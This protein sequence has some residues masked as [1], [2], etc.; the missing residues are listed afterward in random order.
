MVLTPLPLIITANVAVGRPWAHQ[1]IAILGGITA[2][3]AFLVG[4]LDAAGAISVFVLPNGESQIPL[5]VGLMASAV[6][7]ATVTSKPVRQ[8][9]SRHLPL[10]PDNPVHALALVLAVLVFGTQAAAILFTSAASSSPSA[11][12]V[13]DLLAQD[14]GLLVLAAAGV[15]IFMRRDVT[16]AAA[17]LGLVK[18]AWWQVVLALA[19]AGAMFAF[20]VAMIELSRSWTP[21]LFREVSANTNQLFGGLVSAP[22]GIVLLAIAPGI[23]EEILFRGALQPRIGLIATAL[24]FTASHAQYGLSLILVSVFASALGLGL[25]RKFTNTTTSAISHATYNLLVG[26][27]VAD[28]QVDAAVAIEVVLVAI[29]AYAIWSQRRGPAMPAES[30]TDRVAEPK[31]IE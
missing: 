12:S 5:D 19:T 10:D 17:R 31:R 24:L 29:S 25:L 1:A 30:L 6:V 4:A 23:C 18:P 15:G 2:G 11:L 8:R 26:I 13:G 27:G 20:S 16:Q 22:L 7:A 14:A 21:D 3:L 28:S 9:L